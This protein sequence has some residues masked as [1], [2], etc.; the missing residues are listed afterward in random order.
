MSQFNQF[1]Y[2][3]HSDTNI[4]GFDII[5]ISVLFL[6][7]VFKVL[8]QKSNLNTYKRQPLFLFVLTVKLLIINV[9]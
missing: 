3:V 8:L 4:I 5:S 6:L 9:S 1:K 7:I 2:K